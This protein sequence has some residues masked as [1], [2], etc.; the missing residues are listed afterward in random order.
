MATWRLPAPLIRFYDNGAL[1]SKFTSQ[2]ERVRCL[3]TALQRLKVTGTRMPSKS[4]S[5]RQFKVRPRTTLTADLGMRIQTFKNKCYRRM[6]CISFREHKT[7][8]YVWQQVSMLAVRQEL[9]LPAVKRRKLSC[10][11]H[12]CPHDMLPEIKSY[13]EDRAN[14]GRTTLRN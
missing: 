11:G 9:L 3:L 2:N 1:T 14:H 4:H 8:E 6:I 7:N 10:F 12:V 13:K 5:F